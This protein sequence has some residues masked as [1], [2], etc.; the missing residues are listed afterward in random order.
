ME[1]ETY[2]T[3]PRIKTLD[4]FALAIRQP[5]RT[6]YITK[7][8]FNAVRDLWLTD[9]ID[10]LPENMIFDTKEKAEHYLEIITSLHNLSHCDIYVKPIKVLMYNNIR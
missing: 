6:L 10:D 8:F 1:S 5:C 4:K 9:D 3:L 2:K 7:V